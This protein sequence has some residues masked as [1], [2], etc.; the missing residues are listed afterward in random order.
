MTSRFHD[1]TVMIT[2]GGGGI[3]SELTRRFASEGALVLC[4]DVDRERAERACETAGEQAR[5]VVC[6][7]TDGDALDRV[8]ADHGAVD[9]LVNNSLC[10][11]GD[12]L[13]QTSDNSL[14][15]ALGVPFDRRTLF[16][17]KLLQLLPRLRRQERADE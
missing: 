1:R 11:T 12:N 6:D 4:L 7:V 2:G 14:R 15:A 13:V 16:S 8:L 3:G 10:V 5:P 9:V 17:E